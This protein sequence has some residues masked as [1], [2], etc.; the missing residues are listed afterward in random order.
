MP[1]EPP[2]CPGRARRGS[3][4]GPPGDLQAVEH[5]LSG[6]PTESTH[7][8]KQSP[9]YS[10]QP[11]SKGVRCLAV[12]RVL[13]NWWHFC[14]IPELTGKTGCVDPKLLPSSAAQ[15]LVLPKRRLGSC[16]PS[17]LR[18]SRGEQSWAR[19]MRHSTWHTANVK[20]A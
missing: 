7:T 14:S 5:K 3:R 6:F 19:M 4:R 8:A 1:P 10:S 16:P 9:D 15:S 2:P 13:L 18:S 20:L 11:F 17:F 12:C